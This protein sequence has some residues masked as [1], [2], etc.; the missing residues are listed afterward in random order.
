MVDVL[1]FG[2]LCVGMV[3][4]GQLCYVGC[5]FM[6]VFEYVCFI[7]DFGFLVIIGFGC[8]FFVLVM[9]IWFV[10]KWFWCFLLDFKGFGFLE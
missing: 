3:V 5:E 8:V 10:I 4:V 6:D 2:E 1:L 7:L 9:F